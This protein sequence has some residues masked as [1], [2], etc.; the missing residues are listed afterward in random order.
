MYKFHYEHIKVKYQTDVQLCF[1]DTD[2]LLYEVQTEDIYRDMEM[3]KNLYDFSDYPKYHFL[4]SNVNK[5][6][7]GK[8]KDELNGETL[9]EFCGLRAKCYSLLYAKDEGSRKAKGNKK[10]VKERHFRRP[11][12]VDAL[13]TLSTYSVSQNI[14]KSKEHKVSSYNVRETAL[15]AFDVK[16][17]IACDGVHTLAHGHYRANDVECTDNCIH[18]V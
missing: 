15:T 5:K 10:S 3:D 13:K 14:I 8:F 18:I 2:S 6:V 16:R 12:Y 9:E 17:W 7:I 1:S 4:Q 11:H